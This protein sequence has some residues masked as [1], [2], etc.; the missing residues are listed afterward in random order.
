LWVGLK[1]NFKLMTLAES[2]RKALENEHI[3]FD[4]KPFKPHI[5][6]I[7]K[8]G[9]FSE[10]EKY[11]KVLRTENVKITVEK[12]SL[13]HSHRENGKLIYTEIGNIKAK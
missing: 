2:V 4:R 13:M 11:I 3:P 12:F 7:R 10:Q 5:T 9:I 6:V 8:A 1:R